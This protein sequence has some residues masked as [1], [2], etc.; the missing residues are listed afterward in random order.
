[1]AQMYGLESASELI[2]A[3]ICDLIPSHDP[4]NVAYLRA[5][6]RAGHRIENAESHEVDCD[7]NDKYF[8]N[9]LVA[10]PEFLE[11]AKGDLQRE[12]EAIYWSAVA[13]YKSS[14][15]PKNLLGGW[16]RLLD[17]FPESEWAKRVAF[18]RM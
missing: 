8:L 1:M 17:E 11:R 13:A 7:G 3:Q 16:N 4:A 14:D 6:V 2:G 15:D 9:N 12:P 5:F 18:I 10:V